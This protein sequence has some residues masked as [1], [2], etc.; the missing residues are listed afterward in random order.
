MAHGHITVVASEHD[1]T[2]LGHDP[3]FGID[4]GVDRRL[5]A[6]GTDSLYL[7]Y[8]IRK[9]HEPLSSGEEVREEVCPQSEAEDRHILLVYDIPEL[10]YLL[11]RK[12]LR[13]ISYDHIRSDMLRIL[14]LD[15]QVRRDD[16]RLPLKPYTAFNNIRSVSGV[17]ARFNEPDRHPQL[18]I[19]ELGYQRLRGFGRAHRPVFEIQFGH[20]CLPRFCIQILIQ[21]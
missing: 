18:L 17:R 13:F 10:V 4:P 19:V 20:I 6:A 7:R 8:R 16:R 21:L 11:G 1:L 15:I 14:F 2:A 12:E 9:L 3:P 5:S